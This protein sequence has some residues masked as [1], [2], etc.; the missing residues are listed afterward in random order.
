[1]RRTMTQQQLAQY[2]GVEKSPPPAFLAALTVGLGLAAPFQF[3]ALSLTR[4]V[5]LPLLRE[6]G[7][8]REGAD[9]TGLLRAVPFLPPSVIL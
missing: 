9:F 6:Q 4:L 7:P 1:M 2:L 5:R 8:A 3:E